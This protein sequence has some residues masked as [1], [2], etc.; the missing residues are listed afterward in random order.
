V[1]KSNQPTLALNTDEY[2]LIN[3]SLIDPAD[4][5]VRDNVGDVTDL[6]A[7]IRNVG[8]QQPLRVT[9]VGDRFKI[10]AGHR[11]Y[12]AIQSLGDAVSP[13]IPCMV[14]PENMADDTRVAA[15]LV[16]NL[17][18]SDLN[19]IEE[20]HAFLRLTAEFGYKQA[21]L[22]KRIARSTTYVSQRISLLKLPELVIEQ[23]RNDELP[24]AVAV[25]LTRITD[26]ATVLALTANGKVVP[27]PDQIAGAV[28]RIKAT[29]LKAQM[30]EE[31]DARGI[32]HTQERIPNNT[33]TL[34]MITS[35]KELG[36]LAKLPKTA[37]AYVNVS[38]WDGTVKVTFAREMTD[39]EMAKVQEELTA[40]RT[41][42]QRQWA[43]DQA[44]AKEAKLAAMDPKLAEWE[45]AA[46]KARAEHRAACKDHEDKV[47]SATRTWIKQVNQK[48]A[49]RWAAIFTV[50]NGNAYSVLESLDLTCGE[51]EDPEDV[52]VN[53][54]IESAANLAAAVVASLFTQYSGQVPSEIFTARDAYLASHN[55]G[56]EPEL[57][58]P[59]KPD[60][61]GEAAA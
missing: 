33:K 28:N 49:L 35:V 23:V 36:E 4:D 18:R 19:P 56:A 30:I 8:L 53:F 32:R 7:S 3:L 2:R 22:A 45:L 26:D 27:K 43:E 51:D 61:S 52:L 48:D 42:A 14:A 29:K 15:M 17:Q 10:V 9:P 58:L 60:L 1:T 41:E 40:K 55:L 16:E 44:K 13:N 21:D 46:E 20:A 6:A 38:T 25:D 47:E 54:A 50:M 34:G 12:A 24:L 31:L 37:I 5:N 11:R 39:A 59:P 57:V